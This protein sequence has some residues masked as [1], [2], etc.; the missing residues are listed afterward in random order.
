MPPVAQTN[1]PPPVLVL[2]VDQLDTPAFANRFNLSTPNADGSPQRHPAWAATRATMEAIVASA[3]RLTAAE[4]AVN[5]A[6]NAQA[7]REAAHRGT[8]NGVA[9]VPDPHA[10]RRLRASARREIA[11]TK[12]AIEKA[13]ATLGDHARVL[14]AEVVQSIGLDTARS[15]VTDNARGAEARSLLR[16]VT[17]PA[18]KSAMLHEA[19]RAGDREFIAGIL[20]GSPILSGLDREAYTN[21]RT[22]AASAFAPDQSR[23][24]AGVDQ[25]VGILNDADQALDARFGALTGE[26]PSQAAE[27]ERALAALEGGA[28]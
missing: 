12:D 5:L 14:Q 24:L 11:S 20:A 23:L 25:L 10:E 4:Q 1:A 18:D 28:A 3:G 19:M 27:Q 26:G 15:G 8:W 22:E 9:P 6:A 13:R 17:N 16:S 2:G 21:L 7:A